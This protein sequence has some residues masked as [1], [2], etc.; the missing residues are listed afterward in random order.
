MMAFLLSGV[1]LVL[2]ASLTV[3]TFF[4]VAEHRGVYLSGLLPYALVALFL[5]FHLFIHGGHPGHSEH[6]EFTKRGLR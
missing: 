2:L 4:L 6:R 1:R 5:V 3:A